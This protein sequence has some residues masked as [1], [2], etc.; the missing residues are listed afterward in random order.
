MFIFLEAVK[1]TFMERKELSP[2][3]LAFHSWPDFNQHELSASVHSYMHK[4]VQTYPHTHIQIFLTSTTLKKLH[5][6]QYFSD[7]LNIFSS[8]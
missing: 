1:L 3:H 6:L 2:A 7:A 8:I 5:F 4:Y